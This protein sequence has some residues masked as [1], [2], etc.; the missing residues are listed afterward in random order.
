MVTQ[1]F[2]DLAQ[3]IEAIKS[4]N[5]QKVIAIDGGGG[6]GKS[7]F[8]EMLAHNVSNAFVIKIDDF[9]KGPWDY[10]LD[11][12]NY[13]VNPLFDWDRFYREVLKPIQKG[14][15]ITYHVYDWKKHT[16]DEVR[17]V[18]SDATVIIE[19]GFS[20][21]RAYADIYDFKIWVQAGVNIRLDRA[22][23]RDGEHMR[24]LWV[25]D[26]IPVEK[27]Y[28]DTQNPA[29]RADLVV[30]THTHDFSDGRFETLSN[31]SR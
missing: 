3:R 19:G 31:F 5:R 28:V 13:E 2:Q 20:L 7:T 29:A 12:T 22:L 18:P 30:L 1:S 14:N 4:K 26:W 17:S 25:E 16:T 27:S 10:R 6:S 15:P 11:H 9:Y 23:K 21:Q 24:A 8:A